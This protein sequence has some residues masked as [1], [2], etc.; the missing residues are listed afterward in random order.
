MALDTQTFGMSRY[1]LSVALKRLPSQPTLFGPRSL[2]DARKAFLAGKNQVVAIKNWLVCAEIVEIQK[3][4]A[5]LTD[6]GKLMAA[7]DPRAEDAWTW[8]LFHLHLCV[9]VD[10]FPYRSFFRL[11]EPDNKRWRTFESLIEELFNSQEGD[12]SVS[13]KSVTTYFEGIE[14]TFRPTWPIYGL[15]L[16]E[17]RKVTD[18]GKERIRRGRV[19]TDDLVVLYSVLLFQ[20]R[21]ATGRQT[22]EARRLLEQGLSR[23][24]G[25]RDGDLR[26]ALGRIHQDSKIGDFIHYSQTANLDSIQFARSGDPA[27]KNLRVYGYQKGKIRWP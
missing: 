14:R 21:F 15:G 2:S 10:A 26:E 18:S 1:W 17:R 7:R 11:I 27:L 16:V 8:W 5:V 9:N 13:K 24:L 6:L 4:Q 25:M 23:I 22:V 19:T 12:A 20:L 3:G